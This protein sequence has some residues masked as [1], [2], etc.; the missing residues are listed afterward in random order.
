L[1][2]AF[3]E[4]LLPGSAPYRGQAWSRCGWSWALAN[5]RMAWSDAIAVL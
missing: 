4:Q 5:R 1:P 3:A 2:R